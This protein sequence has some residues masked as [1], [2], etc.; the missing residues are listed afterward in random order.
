MQVEVA[1][2]EWAYERGGV[3][4]LGR[5]SDPELVEAVREHLVQQLGSERQGGPAALRLLRPVPEDGDDTGE[6]S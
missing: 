1:L 2:L 6:S 5:S 3:R 4:L